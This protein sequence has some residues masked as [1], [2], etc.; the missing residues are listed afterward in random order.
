[1]RALV[2]TLLSSSAIAGPTLT[3]DAYLV[4][5]P[6]EASITVNGAA[7]PV[8]TLP[9]AADGSVK[10]TCDL[11]SLALGSYTIVLTVANVA[12]CSAATSPA[13]CTK[14]GRASSAPFFL[15]L[16]GGSVSAPVVRVAP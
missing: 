13:T 1:M 11:T 4:N 14:E 2:L 6:T 15:T 9:K 5:Q 16:V 8:C 10:P 3:A 12:G 7:G